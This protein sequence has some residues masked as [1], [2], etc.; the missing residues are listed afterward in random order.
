MQHWIAN[1]S[2]KKTD[3]DDYRLIFSSTEGHIIQLYT[4]KL[5][6]ERIFSQVINKRDST[7]NNFGYIELY[8]KFDDVIRAKHILEL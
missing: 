8:V 3:F 1:L 4:M 5:D 2:P 6:E 7:Y